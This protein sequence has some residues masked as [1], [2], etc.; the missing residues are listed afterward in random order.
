[1]KTQKYVFRINFSLGILTKRSEV[2]PPRVN[3]I[4]CVY[5]MVSRG[6]KLSDEFWKLYVLKIFF[7]LEFSVVN[8]KS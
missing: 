1:M 6:L 3:R 8:Q 2:L 5:S 7:K 4:I